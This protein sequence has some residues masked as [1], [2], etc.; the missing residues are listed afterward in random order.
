MREREEKSSS[1]RINLPSS[2]TIAI[3]I[4]VVA[5]GFL[6]A[7]ITL[8]LLQIQVVNQV[9]PGTQESTSSTGGLETTIALLAAFGGILLF[10]FGQFWSQLNS[11]N[12]QFSSLTS[13]T[14]QKIREQIELQAESAAG[15]YERL[16]SR[17]ENI[18]DQY[19]WLGD[20]DDLG[21]VTNVKTSSAVLDTFSSLLTSNQENYAYEWLMESS[22]DSDLSG[23]AANFLGLAIISN[24]L[25]RD[26][27]LTQW[28][29]RRID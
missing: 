7:Q 13:S 11:L 15:R 18:S 23:S 6:V 22:N 5:V 19:P 28:F 8:P 3:S 9:V 12:Q 29:L 4:I 21:V 1:V 25:Y 16:T 2:R 20:F 17:I 14:D 27:H 24:V 10:I 26:E